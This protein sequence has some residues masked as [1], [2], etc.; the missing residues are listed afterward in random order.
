MDSLQALKPRVKVPFPSYQLSIRRPCLPCLAFVCKNQLYIYMGVSLNGGTPKPQNTPKLSCLVGK[1]MVVWYHHFRKPPYDELIAFRC[2]FLTYGETM[3][4]SCKVPMRRLHLPGQMT[5]GPS[6]TSRREYVSYVDIFWFQKFAI[7]FGIQ[8][9]CSSFSRNE[10]RMLNMTMENPPFEDVFPVASF[11][12]VHCQFSGVQH[13]SSW[14]LQV[15]GTQDSTLTNVF[16]DMDNQPYLY[17][18]I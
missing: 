1:P 17:S 3:L 13:P 15:N 11:R 18:E 14:N 7:Q 10:G 5:G 8:F 4:T 6:G 2:F 12:M 16:D 9:L